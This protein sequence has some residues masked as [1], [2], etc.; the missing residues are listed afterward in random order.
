MLTV[1]ERVK[2]RVKRK[3]NRLRKQYP[4]L[5]A[6]LQPGGAL[7]DWLVTEQQAASDLAAIIQSKDT[8]LA[9]VAANDQRREV[10][11]FHLRSLVAAVVSSDDLARR[12]ARRITYPVAGAYTAEFWFAELRAVA[13]SMAQAH[14]E[15]RESHARFAAWHDRCP[16]CHLP[17]PKPPT[18]TLPQVEQSML[19]F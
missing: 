10:K 2:R 15:H 13:P 6:E 1:E 3:N 14:C 7:A 17:L 19:P 5:A 12:D 11:G 8:M 18:A 9:R 4:L 16:R